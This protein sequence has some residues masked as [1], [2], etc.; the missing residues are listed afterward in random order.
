MAAPARCS[1]GT[2]APLVVTI[3]VTFRAGAGQRPQAPRSSKSRHHSDGQRPSAGERGY[4]PLLNLGGPMCRRALPALLGL[5]RASLAAAA[6]VACAH[7]ERPASMPAVLTPSS[8]RKLSAIPSR[9]WDFSRERHRCAD[10]CAK[11]HARKLALVGVMGSRVRVAPGPLALTPRVVAQTEVSGNRTPPG[12]KSPGGV[13]S[14]G[15]RRRAGPALGSGSGSTGSPG[16][17]RRFLGLRRERLE[18]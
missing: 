5:A 6:F 18:G 7:R 8:P 1:E 12:E 13:L 14:A 3:P 15:L 2:P 10:R 9:P 11:P 17:Q 4:D 16:L